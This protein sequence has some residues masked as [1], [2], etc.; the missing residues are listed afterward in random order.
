MGGDGEGWGPLA[1]GGSG[2]GP[3][4]PCCV[5]VDWTRA[6]LGP[7]AAGGSGVGPLCSCCEGVE[8]AATVVV[9]GSAGM[10][11]QV[12]ELS[13]QLPAGSTHSLKCLKKWEPKMGNLTA[14]N[15]KFYVKEC[16]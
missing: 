14:A 16:S 4:S 12:R 6:G 13:N 5:D 8:M 15:K 1:A 10:A 9:S 11:A 3:L 7:Q 2:V